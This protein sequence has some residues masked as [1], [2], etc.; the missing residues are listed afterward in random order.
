MESLK[1]EGGGFES[2][3]SVRK[4]VAIDIRRSEKLPRKKLTTSAGIPIPCNFLEYSARDLVLLFVTK[5]ICLPNGRGTTVG[6]EH[7]IRFERAFPG[8][9]PSK[10]KK[11]AWETHPM[12]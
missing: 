7:S 9:W 3:M 10:G 4:R 11:R 12:I 2:G 5:N 6:G 1:G 8:L